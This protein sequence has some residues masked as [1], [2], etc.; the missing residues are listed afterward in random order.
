MDFNIKLSNGQLLRGVIHSPGDNIRAVVLLVHG[1]GEHILRYEDWAG[2]FRKE[3]IAF[4]GVDLPGHGRSD[5]RRGHIKNYAL[6][7]E[8]IDIMID[9]CRKTFPGTPVFI[10]GHSLG[11]GIVASYILRKNPRIK[12]AVITSP[13]LALVSEPSKFKKLLVSVVRRVAPGLVQPSGLDAS[14]I[15]HDPAVVEKYR[16]DPMV[17]DRISVS[18]FDGATR[19]AAYSMEHA[20]DLKI[21]ALIMHGGDDRITSPEASRIFAGKSSKAHFRLWEGGFHELHNEPFRDEVFIYI[22]NWIRYQ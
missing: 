10:Y 21:P 16:T 18:L 11:G 4:T 5:G 6:L 2:K 8:M 22:L 9:S 7:D 3:G 15:S 19:A 13:W 1:L 12:G 14:H 17:H 20:G